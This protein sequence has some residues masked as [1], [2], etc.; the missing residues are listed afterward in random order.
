[1]IT[2][3]GKDYPLWSQFVEKKDEWIGG[4]LQDSGDSMD[5]SMGLS[6]GWMTT[7]IVDILLQ[8][9]GKDS[10]F[11]LVEGVDF[12]CGA[13]VHHLGISGDGEE[14]WITLIGYMGHRWR[15]KQKK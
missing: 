3:N 10:A 7:V 6:K 2:I 5:R 4:I 13:D 15:I 14:G 8:E 11:F 9:N 1:M 12:S